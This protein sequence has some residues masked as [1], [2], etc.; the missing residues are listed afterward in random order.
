MYTDSS[1]LKG[2]VVISS[3]KRTLKLKQTDSV[4]DKYGRMDE[5]SRS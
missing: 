5:S 3:D 1:P 2:N 4:T